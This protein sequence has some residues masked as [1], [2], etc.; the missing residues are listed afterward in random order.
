MDRIDSRINA[1]T[2]ASSSISNHTVNVDLF[3]IPR[4]F[5]SPET[6]TMSDEWARVFVSQLKWNSR[7]KVGKKSLNVKSDI[8]PKAKIRIHW[9]CIVHVYCIVYSVVYAAFFS[10]SMFNWM[11]YTR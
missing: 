5:K 10:G 1:H 4:G 8:E 2:I 9:M 11:I 7:L 3:S 6:L